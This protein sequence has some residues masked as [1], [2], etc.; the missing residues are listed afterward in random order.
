SAGIRERDPI[1]IA[2]DIP[3]D[4]LAESADLADGERARR[5]LERSF[6]RLGRRG[7]DRRHLHDDAL[8][9]RTRRALVHLRQPRL[10]DHGADLAPGFQTTHPTLGYRQT[11]PR[12]LLR[13]ETSF[14]QRTF[15][16]ALGQRERAPVCLARFG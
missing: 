14:E 1:S 3:V 8:A 13:A 12:N 5:A 6:D 16:G 10:A 11:L 2:F 4:D 7:V 15:R 9:V